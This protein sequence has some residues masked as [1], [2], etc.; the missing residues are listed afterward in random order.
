MLFVIP[1]R[2]RN[3]SEWSLHHELGFGIGLAQVG[4]SRRNSG[5]TGVCIGSIYLWDKR[6]SSKLVVRTC[7]E[8]KT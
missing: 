6:K 8:L 3:R 1:R 2:S 7:S 4:G 5:K